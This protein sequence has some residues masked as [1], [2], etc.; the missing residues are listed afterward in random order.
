MLPHAG[1]RGYMASV[2][3]HSQQS[4][5]FGSTPSGIRTPDFLHVREALLAAELMV[6]D[7]TTPNVRIELTAFGLESKMLPLHQFGKDY[8]PTVRIELTSP[9]YEGGTSPGMLCR[10]LPI[11]NATPIG[12]IMHFRGLASLGRQHH[13]KLTLRIELRIHPYQG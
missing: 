6:Q 7:T 13:S 12:T 9:R 10:H 3:T 11:T 4:P 8:K 1:Y 5:R 2:L